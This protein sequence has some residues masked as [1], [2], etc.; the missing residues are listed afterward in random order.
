VARLREAAADPKVKFRCV[1]R[2]SAGAIDRSIVANTD[3]LIQIG[4]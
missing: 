1:C 4:V 3:A 2:S